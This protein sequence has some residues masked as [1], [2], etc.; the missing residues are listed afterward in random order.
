MNYFFQPIKELGF[1]HQSPL[2]VWN[3]STVK[4]HTVNT[5]IQYEPIAL[6]ISIGGPVV[7]EESNGQDDNEY[8]VIMPLSGT[9]LELKTSLLYLFPEGTTAGD[10]ALFRVDK[11]KKAKKGAAT[12]QAFLAEHNGK[13]LKEVDFDSQTKLYAEKSKNHGA[14]AK[15]ALEELQRLQRQMDLIIENRCSSST[16]GEAD[17]WPVVPISVD[18]IITVKQLK[19]T[20]RDKLQLGDIEGGGRLRVKEK[21]DDESGDHLIVNEAWVLKDAGISSGSRVIIEPGSPPDIANEIVLKFALCKRALVV[22]NLNQA[23]AR[24]VKTSESSS[25]TPTDAK[26]D[27]TA[28]AP[29]TSQKAETATAADQQYDKDH[30]WELVMPRKVCRSL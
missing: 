28:S 2:F 13:T 27:G 24:D 29:D 11:V 25:S 26:L 8:E 4:E 17:Q 5:G 10:V 19:T 20:I 18:R 23:L 15:N 3:G 6:S 21:N 7:D 22:V 1:K 9:I 12:A 14:S 30:R 16:L